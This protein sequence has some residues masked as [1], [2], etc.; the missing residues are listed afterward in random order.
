[1]KL[2]QSLWKYNMKGHALYPPRLR[3]IQDKCALA[4]LFIW[5]IPAYMTITLAPGHGRQHLKTGENHSHR[6]I[7]LPGKIPHAK[8]D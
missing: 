8:K 6:I 4:D 1:M 5:F 3:K 7:W 2:L